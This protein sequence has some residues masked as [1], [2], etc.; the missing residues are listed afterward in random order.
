MPHIEQRARW[1]VQWMRHDHLCRA[2]HCIRCRGKYLAVRLPR[3]TQV[4]ETRASYCFQIAM[5]F[6]SGTCSV[7]IEQCIR[8]PAESPVGRQ[9]MNDEI[10]LPSSSCIRR[11]EG[12]LFSA[13][14]G[15]IYSLRNEVD[16]RSHV[17]QRAHLRKCGFACRVPPLTTTTS[18]RV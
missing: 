8:D 15:V 1:A 4:P 17:P 10:S 16:A 11:R 12:N 5:V 3:E 9:W 18:L 6:H 2:H 14:F 7:I 13:P